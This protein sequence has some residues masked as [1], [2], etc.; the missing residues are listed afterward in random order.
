VCLLILAVG[1]RGDLP[2]VVA[3]NRDEF[4]GRATAPAAFW[5]DARVLGGRDLV[6]GGTW[7]GVA[8]DGRF[9]AVT[10]V[11]EGGAPR[12]GRRSR[13]FL[14]ADFLRSSAETE[15]FL[16]ERAGE[17]SLYDGFNL[18]AGDAERL[19]WL[20]NRAPRVEP[21]HLAPGVHGIS[22]ALL[23]TP[24]PKLSFATREAR[25]LVE[26]GSSDLSSALFGA[27]SDRT[28]A[29]DDLLPETRIGLER[30]RVLSPV[31]VDTPGYGTRTSTVVLFHAGGRIELEERTHEAGRPGVESRRFAFDAA[32]RAERRRT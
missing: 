20:S 7:L 26:S 25:A 5:E 22:N 10:N 6:A 23:D 8:R 17:A 1:C 13:G 27:L 14:V 28:P 2:L 19:W 4:R 15:A 18:V 3:A 31:F 9:A 29:P 30:E 32:R 11:R 21:V 24:W 16:E 12:T